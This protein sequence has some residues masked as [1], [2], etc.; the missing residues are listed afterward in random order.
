MEMVLVV[1]C[2]VLMTLLAMAA[3]VVY[4]MAREVVS[5][6]RRLD[7]SE[8]LREHETEILRH[9]LSE[10]EADLEEADESCKH[11]RLLCGVTTSMDRQS[12]KAS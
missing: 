4:R 11:Y 1:A 9:R 12:S 5:L 2:L 8:R 3:S 10:A 6:Q 7:Q